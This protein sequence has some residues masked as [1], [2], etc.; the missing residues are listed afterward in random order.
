VGLIRQY[1]LFDL[2]R[3]RRYLKYAG[4][5]GE[6]KPM[7]RRHFVALGAAPSSEFEADVWMAPAGLGGSDSNDGLSINTPKLTFNAAKALLSP[8]MTLGVRN[9]TY[10]GGSNTLNALPNGSSGGGYI[11]IAA[12]NDGGAIFNAGLDMAS[13]D[14][15]IRFVGLRLN[16]GGQRTILGDHIKLIRCSFKGGPTSGS[17]A[18][19]VIGSSGETAADILLEECWCYGLGGRYNFLVY[20]ADRVLLRRCLARHDGGF[21]DFEPEACFNVYNSSDCHL[22]NCIAIDSD[23][24]YGSGG[25]QAGFYAVQNTS[26]DPHATANDTW[27]GCLCLNDVNLAWRLD[28]QGGAITGAVLTDNVGWDCKNG[29]VSFGTGSCS[30]T[31]NRMTIGRSLETMSGDFMGGFGSFGSG[32]KTITNVIIYDMTADDLDGVSATFFDTFSNGGTST[33][34]GRQTYD[35]LANGLTYLPRI[36]ASTPLKTDGSSGGQIGA[37]I[38]NKIGVSETL[39]GETDWNI[40]TGV[41]LW[42]F[43]NQSRIKSE[44]SEVSTRGF[45]AATNLTSYIWGYLGNGSPF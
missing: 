13:S 20:N 2:A 8:G 7:G 32:T 38:V 12:E 9:G 36:E 26:S 37:Q 23:Q 5:M 18:A 25:Y 24:A 11:T 14:Q 6:M 10:T 35:P 28:Q 1:D 45:C 42:P 31:V 30:A 41:S 22:Q 4:S 44:L 16:D 19:V 15:Y 34:T 27:V 33:G 43:P 39:K 21:D 3:V 40:D 29:G 17:G